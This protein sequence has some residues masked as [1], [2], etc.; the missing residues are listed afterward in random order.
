MNGPALLCEEEDEE[1]CDVVVAVLL[2]VELECEGALR[3]IPAAAVPRITTATATIISEDERFVQA[4]GPPAK[5]NFAYSDGQTATRFAD[6]R[7]R[8]GDQS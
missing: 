3:K 4:R 2:V 8:A 6:V 1:E 5:L 7:S